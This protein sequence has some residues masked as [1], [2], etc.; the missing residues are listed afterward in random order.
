VRGD[1][2]AVAQAADIDL[3]TGRV[4]LER[5]FDRAQRV[6][7]SIGTVSSSVSEDDRLWSGKAQW[8]GHL[9]GT[10]ASSSR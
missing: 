2:G 7:R 4:Y 8:Y 1:E 5:A 6:F 10:H 3:D 9:P